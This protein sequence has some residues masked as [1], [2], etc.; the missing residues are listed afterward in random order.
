MLIYSIDFFL[1]GIIKYEKKFGQQIFIEGNRH[2]KDNNNDDDDKNKPNNC[3]DISRDKVAR[4]LTRKLRHGLKKKKRNLNRE[5]EYLLRAAKNNAIRTNYS[6]GKIDD[7]QQNNKC[8]LC[9]DSD[10]TFNYM[11]ECSKLAEKEYKTKYDWVG[12]E[13][14]W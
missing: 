4:L 2:N 7:K 10:E 5:T 13:I 12:M 3:F 6:R 9:G 11:R 1:T 14:H 8:R